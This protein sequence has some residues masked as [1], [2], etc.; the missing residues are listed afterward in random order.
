MRTIRNSQNN[1]KI[2]FKAF[3]FAYFPYLPIPEITR[4]KAQAYGRSL[5]ETVV[6]NPA[7]GI[8]ACILG[9]LCAVK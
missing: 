4:S 9:L 8:D 6:S 7:E 3:F 1:R 5:A 2:P